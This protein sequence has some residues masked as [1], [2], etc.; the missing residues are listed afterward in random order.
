MP[1]STSEEPNFEQLSQGTSQDAVNSALDEQFTPSDE[2][3]LQLNELEW[4]ITLN[5]WVSDEVA[6]RAKQS[7]SLN[8]NLAGTFPATSHSKQILWECPI[9]PLPTEKRAQKWKTTKQT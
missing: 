9:P 2:Q 6:K 8:V 5:T 1:E 7:L 3:N 4:F